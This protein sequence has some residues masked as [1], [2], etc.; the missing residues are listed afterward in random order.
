MVEFEPA[1][2]APVEPGYRFSRTHT[3]DEEQ[4]RAF[5]LAAGDE[6]PLHHDAAFARGTRFGGMIASGTHTTSLLMGLTATH[7]AKKGNVLGINFSVDLL[8]PV[9]ASETVLIE[10]SVSSIAA[11]PRGGS[12]IEL[13]GCMK[14]S[15][16]R[17]RVLAHGTVLLTS[18]A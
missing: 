10:W 6:N 7:F 18:G 13:Q 12:I 17:T 14:G 1:A 4:V 15:D 2:G 3:F 11:R 5:A 9:L 8:R 16:D